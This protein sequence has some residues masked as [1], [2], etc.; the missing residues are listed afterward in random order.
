MNGMIDEQFLTALAEKVHRGQEGQLRRGFIPGGRCYGYRNVPLED[1]A[2]QALIRC[3]SN[4]LGSEFGAN[5][6]SAER[7]VR[8]RRA[9]RRGRYRELR[10]S[11]KFY[12][13]KDIR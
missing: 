2:G 3:S 6:Y 1:R 4:R 8:V 11:L 7:A 12:S 13:L 10:G 5:R 9:K